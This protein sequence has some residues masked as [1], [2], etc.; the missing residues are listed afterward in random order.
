MKTYV[1]CRNEG[2]YESETCAI[3]KAN[4]EGYTPLKH[5]LKKIGENQLTEKITN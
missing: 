3:S 2:L 1:E 4:K 5:C